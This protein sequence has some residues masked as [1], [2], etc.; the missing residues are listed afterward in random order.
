MF[1]FVK[2]HGS[3]NLNYH[4]LKSNFYKSLGSANVMSKQHGTINPKF[5]YLANPII[6]IQK[7]VKC[8]RKSGSA[9]KNV[10]KE[11]NTSKAKRGEVGAVA[12]F[13]IFLTKIKFLFL[14]L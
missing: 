3:H 4:L 10:Q 2:L 7:V 6:A 1:V 12:F 11:R 9:L 13:S 8:F 5:H 14:F